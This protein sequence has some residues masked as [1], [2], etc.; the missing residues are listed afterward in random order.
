MNWVAPIK[1]QKTLVLFGEKLKEVDYKYYIMFELGVGTGLQLQ[2][3]L[4]FK[5]K[6]VRN[7]KKITVK[8]GKKGV[9]NVYDIPENLQKIIKEFTDGKDPETYLILGHSTNNKPVSREQAYRVLR[10]VHGAEF[11]WC[12]DNEKD[13]CMELL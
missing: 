2:D 1:D 12:A 11:D 4:A 9:K 8:I 13:F 6:D 3:I 5:I 7:K 10:S